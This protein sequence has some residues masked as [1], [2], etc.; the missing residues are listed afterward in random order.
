MSTLSRRGF[1]PA[2]AALVLAAG[3]SETTSQERSSGGRESAGAVS[4]RPRNDSSYGDVRVVVYQPP[5][6]TRDGKSTAD[7][8]MI[9][10]NENHDG[11]Q[12]EQGRYQIALQDPNRGYKVMTEDQTAS[13]LKSLENLGY[14]EAATPFVAGDEALLTNSG[15][16]R[17]RGVI[18]VETKAGRFKVPGQRPSGSTDAAG[19][20]RYEQFVN[21][22]T[23]IAAW[24]Q[25]TVGELPVGGA[26]P[27]PIRLDASK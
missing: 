15:G 4:A 27:K 5:N 25:S 7:I 22:K 16:D 3:C 17:Y 13:L 20:R 26:T 11:R 10:V 21:L 23:A 9:L 1:L 2:F 8:W 6:R 14:F 24:Y 12:S 19:Q 18:Y